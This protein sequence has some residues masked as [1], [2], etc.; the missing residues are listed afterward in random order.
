MPAMPHLVNRY[1]TVLPLLA[2]LAIAAGPAAGPEP[3]SAHHLCGNTGSPYG[4]FDL[5]TYEAADYR[6]TYARTMELSGFNQLL[7]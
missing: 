7:P 2:L 1:W 5:Q 4:A 3:A 6:N